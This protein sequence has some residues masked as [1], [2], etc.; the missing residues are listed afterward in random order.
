[1]TGMQLQSNSEPFD[2]DIKSQTVRHGSEAYP[3]QKQRYTSVQTKVLGPNPY[4]NNKSVDKTHS[5]R[6][7]N[8]HEDFLAIKEEPIR[9]APESPYLNA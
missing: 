5:N 8:Q 7:S 3:K 6:A 9:V 1:M 4:H 2:K